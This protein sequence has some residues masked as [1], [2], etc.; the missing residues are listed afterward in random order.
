MRF[1]PWKH[2]QTSESFGPYHRFWWRTA[3]LNTQDMIVS[4]KKKKREKNQHASLCS[5]S[6]DSSPSA[7]HQFMTSTKSVNTLSKVK[8]P[9]ISGAAAF[10]CNL[11]TCSLGHIV[12]LNSDVLRAWFT[13]ECRWAQ[14]LPSPGSDTERGAQ[15]FPQP[16]ICL[17]V[18]GGVET[19]CDLLN[20]VWVYVEVSV[21]S[22]GS[23]RPTRIIAAVCLTFTRWLWHSHR[24]SGRSDEECAYQYWQ[25]AHYIL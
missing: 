10:I 7:R 16:R 8:D 25:Y 24:G 17:L 4:K 22:Y 21:A 14:S 13:A 23:L 6:C 2:V 9:E 12:L 11:Q 5:L 3:A 19:L 15:P 1:S 20:L 18:V